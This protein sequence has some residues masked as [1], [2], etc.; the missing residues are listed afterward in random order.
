[1]DSEYTTIDDNFLPPNDYSRC[2]FAWE[3]VRDTSMISISLVSLWVLWKMKDN[4]ESFT[5]ELENAKTQ[6]NLT[7]VGSCIHK[8]CHILPF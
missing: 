6:I 2:R 4:V 8:I 5:S 3:V 7:E 1:M